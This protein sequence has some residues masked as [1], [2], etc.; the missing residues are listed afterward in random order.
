[1]PVREIAQESWRDA[2][3]SF[4]RQHEGSI[5]SI[6][7]RD[8]RG[9]VAVTAHDVPLQG[10]SPASPLSNDIAI[11]V[12][13]GRSHLTHEVRDPASLELDL[14]ANEAE[15]ALIIHGTDGSATTIEFR[16]PMRADE[17]DRLPVRNRR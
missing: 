6:T 7:T 4:S 8:P 3:D 5:V 17:M 2:L 10:V 11:I 15:R 9:E 12:G 13:G 1:M 14:T 16:W